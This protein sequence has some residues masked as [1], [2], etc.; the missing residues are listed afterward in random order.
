[1]LYVCL[2]VLGL[3][4]VL[5]TTFV[6]RRSLLDRAASI[7]VSAA[8]LGALNGKYDERNPPDFRCLIQLADLCPVDNQEARWHVRIVSYYF[9]FLS[10]VA[11]FSSKLPIRFHGF[12][13]KEQQACVHFAAITLDRRVNRSRLL[14]RSASSNDDVP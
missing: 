10:F 2:F 5:G 1:M 6:C 14:V 8:A 11:R 12:V 7:A 13:E 3:T 9:A 4:F